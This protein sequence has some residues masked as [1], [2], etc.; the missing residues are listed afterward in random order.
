[1]SKTVALA[2][3]VRSAVLRMAQAEL[4]HFI[5]SLYAFALTFKTGKGKI[6]LVKKYKYSVFWEEHI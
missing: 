1:M 2:T 6:N 4:L 5:K 3:I